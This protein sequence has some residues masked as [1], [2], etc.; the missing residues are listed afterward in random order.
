MQILKEGFVPGLR[1]F[2]EALARCS[3]YAMDTEF[4]G[5]WSKEIMSSDPFDTPALRYQKIKHSAERMCLTQYGVCTFEVLS[6]KVLAR[7]FSFYVFPAETGQGNHAVFSVQASAMHFLAKN[8]FDFNKWV[9]EGIPFVSPSREET[10]RAQIETPADRR[11]VTIKNPADLTLVESIFAK[12]ETWSSALHNTDEDVGQCLDLEDTNNPFIRRFLYQEIPRK[13][14]NRNW[15]LE[16]IERPVNEEDSAGGEEKIEPSPK[17]KVPA[18][19]MR[20]AVQSAAERAA[21]EAEAKQK[22]E[23]ELLAQIGMR[24]V[25]DAMKASQK[26]CVV[27]NGFMDLVLTLAHFSTSPD[28]LD[29]FKR[30]VLS[31]WSPCFIDTKHV[32]IQVAKEYGLRMHGPSHLGRLYAFLEGERFASAPAIV[33]ATEDSDVSVASA[34]NQAHDASWDAY[35]TGVVFLRMLNFVAVAQESAADAAQPMHDDTDGSEEKEKESKQAP[36]EEPLVFLSDRVQALLEQREGSAAMLWQNRLQ[37][38]G[39]DWHLNLAGEDEEPS[40]ELALLFEGDFPWSEGDTPIR[41]LLTD[42]QL[43]R[44]KWHGD[45]ALSAWFPDI[46]VLEAAVAHCQTQPIAQTHRIL[47]MSEFVAERR[48]AIVAALAGHC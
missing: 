40:C 45:H 48:A 34:V 2:Q 29:D 47:R 41:T 25:F 16:K 44:T 46:D 3:F 26:P 13:W 28:S 8:N 43:Q 42:F 7:S 33:Q 6:E 15:R 18:V 10:L 22:R 20:I 4:T 9:R 1:L 32:F 5:L 30:Q 37:L 31:E 39:S 24:A 19:S 27:H 36:A 38:Y 21:E 12:I 35:M 17:R 14:P 23:E 11:D